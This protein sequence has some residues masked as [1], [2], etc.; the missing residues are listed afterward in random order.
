M[1]ISYEMFWHMATITVWHRKDKGSKPNWNITA[2]NRKVCLCGKDSRYKQDICGSP[3]DEQING[4]KKPDE[5]GN[6][7][8]SYLMD[9]HII[10]LHSVINISERFTFHSVEFVRFMLP[11]CLFWFV[12]KLKPT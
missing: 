1:I 2:G 12:L 8:I 6:V 5:D 7:G 11:E 10:S 3:T 4:I 9:V